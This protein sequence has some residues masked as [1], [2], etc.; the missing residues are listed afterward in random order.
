MKNTDKLIEHKLTAGGN[1]YIIK[2]PVQLSVQ[3]QI[4]V[5]NLRFS[6]DYKRE[7]V[8]GTATVIYHVPQQQ[9]ES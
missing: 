9:P 5:L 1:D 8:P 3:E 4:A 6:R 2:S 7:V